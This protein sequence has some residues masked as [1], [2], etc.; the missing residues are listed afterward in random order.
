[1]KK[2]SFILVLIAFLLISCAPKKPVI[3]TANLTPKTVLFMDNEGLLYEFQVKHKL[4]YQGKKL[5][6]DF[7][8][9]YIYL[10]NNTK[11]AQPAP[12]YL[13]I[14]DKDKVYV[15]L[16]TPAY[17]ACYLLDYYPGID[18][19]NTKMKALALSRLNTSPPPPPPQTNVIINNNPY[20]GYIGYVPDRWSSLGYQTG[21]AMGEGFKYGLI[22]GMLEAQEEKR[23]TWL[24]YYN[25]FKNHM[26]S[27]P[28]TIEAG[29][30]IKGQLWFKIKREQLPLTV[31]II[32]D[33]Y[34]V[35][36]PIKT[37]SETIEKQ[38][39]GEVK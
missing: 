10:I 32:K 24:L 12:K 7:Y 6:K 30:A 1:M 3:K 38:S 36:I 9:L 21:A 15:K 11:K 25:A 17:M 8:A 13:A 33:S 19:S 37:I 2:V 22:L 39:S 26:F 16:L 20:G 35:E 27:C 28:Q 4:I 29:R 5:V 31:V 18:D 14:K 34:Y 23:K